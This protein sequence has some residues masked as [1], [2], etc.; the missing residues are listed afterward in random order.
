M[1]WWKKERK[2]KKR[3]EEGEEE[4]DVGGRKRVRWIVR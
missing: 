4:V 1:R 2:E 3:E